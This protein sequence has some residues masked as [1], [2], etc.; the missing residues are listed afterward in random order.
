LIEVLIFLKSTKVE[1]CNYAYRRLLLW[2]PL[3]VK[4]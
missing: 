3:S 2:K 1:T 4:L